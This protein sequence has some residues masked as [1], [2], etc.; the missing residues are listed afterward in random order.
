[1]KSVILGPMQTA[2]LAFALLH[3]LTGSASSCDLAFCYDPQSGQCLNAAGTVGLNAFN[4]SRTQATG[5]AECT[6][7]GDTEFLSTGQTPLFGTSK[8]L[9]M[10]KNFVNLNLKGADLTKA[11]FSPYVTFAGAELEGTNISTLILIYHAGISGEI[12]TFTKTMIGMPN[13]KAV[14]DSAGRLIYSCKTVH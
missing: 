11:I 13:C 1:M 14:P 3:A 9:T 12:D 10:P 2:I 8:T 7:L 4:E 6:D 5:T